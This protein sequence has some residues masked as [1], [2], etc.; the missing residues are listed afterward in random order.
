MLMLLTAYRNIMKLRII[1]ES[2]KKIKEKLSYIIIVSVI[3]VIT[4][5]STK[6]D[7][8]IEKEEIAVEQ[9]ELAKEREELAEEYN[10]LCKEYDELRQEYNREKKEFQKSVAKEKKSSHKIHTN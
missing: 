3:C 1:V 4:S 2:M 5:C 6:S 8:E 9:A 10:E 7:Y